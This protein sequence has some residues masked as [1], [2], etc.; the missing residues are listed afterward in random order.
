MAE[1]TPDVPDERA[2]DPAPWVGPD[3]S[4]AL[5]WL[6]AP[7]ADALAQ[8]GH[9][10]LVVG[11]PGVGALELQ[12]ALAQR[13]LCEADMGAARGALPCGVCTACRLVQAR[14]HPD[15]RVLLPEALRVAHGWEA[16][17]GEGADSGARAGRKPSRWIRIAELRAAIDWMATTPG[18]GRAKVMLLHPGEAMQWD[19]ASALLKT[20]EEPPAGTRIVLSCS[21]PERLLPTVR[22][23]CQ[24][25]RLAPPSQRVALAWLAARGVA[26]PAVLLAASGGQPL[27][28]LALHAAGVD[29]AAWT[30]LPRALAA[31]RADA[32]AG[33]P[34][35]RALD[36]LHKLAHDLQAVAV[37]A[38][39]VYFPP[40]TL[41][42]AMPGLSGDAV[43]PG[44]AGGTGTAPPG[45]DGAARAVS[46]LGDWAREIGRALARAEHPWNEALL[47]ESLM[48]QG[49]GALATLHR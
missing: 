44:A 48:A 25:V 27:D 2:R 21:D 32:W 29:A 19:A 37:G 14:S 43:A 26:D 12:A 15:L 36:A 34:L 17:E 20:L 4:L 41:T 47:L 6:A 1:P 33:W 30:E 31:G 35:P 49:R 10:L 39:P 45:A 11:G 23:R 28:A 18:R 22:S 13:W 42:P 3:A 40:T 38:F 46:A 16:P 5:P 24:Q 8:P 7:L 9:A